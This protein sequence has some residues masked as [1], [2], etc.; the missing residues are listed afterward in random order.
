MPE[1]NVRVAVAFTFVIGVAGDVGVSAD[2]FTG[3]AETAAGASSCN[4]PHDPHSGQRPSHFGE[5]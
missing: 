1:G 4:V 3:P 5:E 2:V